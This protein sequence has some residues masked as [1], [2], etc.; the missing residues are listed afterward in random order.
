MEYIKRVAK[1]V[2]FDKSLCKKLWKLLFIHS[3][4]LFSSKNEAYWENM[5]FELLPSASICIV[6]IEAHGPNVF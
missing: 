2:I 3:L 4:F 1:A 6:Q 5:D